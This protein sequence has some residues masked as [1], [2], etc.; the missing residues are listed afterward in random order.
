MGAYLDSQRAV[1]NVHRNFSSAAL[2]AV[3][4]YFEAQ[5]DHLRRLQEA[6]AALEDA[7]RK[8]DSSKKRYH[9]ALRSLEALSEQMHHKRADAGCTGAV[10]TPRS[11]LETPGHSPSA[12][13]AMSPP[14]EQMAH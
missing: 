1:H 7:Q 3:T 12:A 2:K 8:V 6:E 14:L 13:A 11:S 5:D 9:A 10:E 4:P